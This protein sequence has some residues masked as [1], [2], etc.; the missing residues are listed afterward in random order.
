MMGDLAIFGA[1]GLTVALLLGALGC[2]RAGLATYRVHRDW[3]IE[4]RLF[5]ATAYAA[6]LRGQ[7][8]VG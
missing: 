6:T 3:L 2:L 5:D 1:G 7:R 4:A 8:A